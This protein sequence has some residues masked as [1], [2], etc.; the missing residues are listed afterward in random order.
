MKL[1]PSLWQ[2]IGAAL[3]FLALSGIFGFGGCM[4]LAD[5]F[6][7]DITLTLGFLWFGIICVAAMWLV[8]R[9]FGSR[10]SKQTDPSDA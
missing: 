3:L 8:L 10:H 5:S 2:A 7:N 6:R 1:R 4:M 9:I